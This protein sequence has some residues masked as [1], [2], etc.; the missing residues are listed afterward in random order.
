MVATLATSSAQAVAPA[1]PAIESQD[2]LLASLTAEQKQQFGDG[3]KA[4]LEHRYAEA[5]AIFKSLLL[6]RP[7]DTFLAKYATECALNIG[8]IAFAKATVTPIAQAAPDDWQAAAMLT[9]VC[10][11]TGDDPC[12]DAG[13]LHLLDLQ[14]RGLVR[15]GMREYVVER[16][17][18]NENSLVISSSF[19]PYST[20]NVYGFAEM[21]NSKG[22]SLLHITLESNDLEQSSWAKHHPKESAAGGR[23]FTLDG[24]R[25]NLP[26]AAGQRTQTHFTFKFLDG[27]PAYPVLRAEFIKIANGETKP[28]SSSSYPLQ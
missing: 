25:T 12:R 18:L 20:Y 17:K 8:D 1:A 19:T 3:T 2:D 24:Y 21:F 28:V 7:L 22:E 26:N 16:I 11:E 23:M 14:H 6:A 15:K 9:R 5:F 4:Y 27:Q 10:A 13:M